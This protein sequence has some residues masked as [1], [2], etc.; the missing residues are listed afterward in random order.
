M[1]SSSPSPPQSGLALCS[2]PLRLRALRFGEPGA[3]PPELSAVHDAANSSE[4]SAHSSANILC[5]LDNATLTK[6]RSYNARVSCQVDFIGSELC[7]PLPW[8]QPFDPAL[9]MRYKAHASARSS[10][11]FDF[12][13]PIILEKLHATGN[14]KFN[15]ALQSEFEPPSSSF[16]VDRD[17]PSWFRSVPDM[18]IS[19]EFESGVMSPL[20]TIF[21]KAP[22]LVSSAPWLPEM[23][24]AFSLEWQAV[25]K[26]L[27][28]YFNLWKC[29]HLML[30]DERFAF[31]FYLDGDDMN[32]PD[33]LIHYYLTG[34]TLPIPASIIVD[35]SPA[36][37]LPPPLWGDRDPLPAT[38]CSEMSPRED[39]ALPP[40][41]PLLNETSTSKS[42][43]QGGQ[44][45]SDDQEIEASAFFTV[46]ELIAFATWHALEL[47]GG[48]KPHTGTP[49]KRKCQFEAP[50]Q[51]H[52][53]ERSLRCTNVD[54]EDERG[55]P[56]VNQPPKSLAKSAIIRRAYRVSMQPTDFQYLNGR[57]H[58]VAARH[59]TL[60][61]LDQGRHVCKDVYLPPISFAES[62]HNSPGAKA[63]SSNCARNHVHVNPSRPNALSGQTTLW[64]RDI[65]PLASGSRNVFVASASSLDPK[66]TSSIQLVLKRF[67][68]NRRAYFLDEILAYEALGGI[69]GD[70][71]PICFGVFCPQ[72]Q[73]GGD[74]NDLFLLLEH[75]E[76]LPLSEAP[77][78]WPRELLRYLRAE[79]EEVVRKIHRAGVLH[80]D[81][82]AR[83]ILVNPET[84]PGVVVVDFDLA[85][86]VGAELAN[87]ATAEMKSDMAAVRWVFGEG[88]E[89]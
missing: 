58:H 28:R 41:T 15:L 26:Q 52:P 36:T 78:R 42:S 8:R 51:T 61:F 73:H 62:S 19:Q 22:H 20:V 87:A 79:A 11:L 88:L 43:P 9:E 66:R 39:T 44:Q 2:P 1:S 31:Y 89:L 12:L 75:F 56:A 53:Y 67:R 23:P 6:F 50:P 74:S 63:P 38:S 3:P 65:R 46:R 40:T 16:M 21:F 60:L 81:L 10:I 69:Q 35:L 32:N 80:A 86:V 64:L 57:V 4:V 70:G 59:H 82:A 17:D 71:V 54:E 45:K 55:Y 84:Q 68:R 49:K 18:A 85:I 29:Q 24:R 27:R 83:N 13:R 7:W 37:D 48:I 5:P 25:A 33:S 77:E 30:L 34:K 76:L 14:Q 72:D 47:E